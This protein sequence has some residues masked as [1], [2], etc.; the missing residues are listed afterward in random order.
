VLPDGSFLVGFEREH[1]L[2]HYPAGTGRPDGIPA[3]LAPPPGLETAPFNGGVETIVSLGDGRLIVLLEE[4]GP[5]PTSR[6]WIGRPGGWQPLALRVEGAL[7]ASDATLLPDGHLLVLERGYD[8][9]RGITSVRLRDVDGDALRAGAVLG[10]RAVAELRPPLTVDNFEG[11]SAW[12]VEGETR[13]L[14]VSDDNFNAAAGQRTLL[15]MFR[16]SRR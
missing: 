6:G 3:R 1:R 9:S 15:L 12:A 2:M 7:R 5:G 8:A 16:I 14:L 13:V 4:S 10:G 11:V